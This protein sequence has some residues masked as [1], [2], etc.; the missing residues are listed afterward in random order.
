MEAAFAW[1]EQVEAVFVRDARRPRGTIQK[2]IRSG[3]V[4]VPIIA[5]KPASHP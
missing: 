3:M 1:Y 2:P 4:A 5:T